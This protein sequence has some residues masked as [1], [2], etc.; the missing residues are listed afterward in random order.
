M[1]AGWDSLDR[2]FEIKYCQ[3]RQLVVV[4]VV[5]VFDAVC[6][7]PAQLAIYLNIYKN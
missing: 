1:S 7:Q 6:A 3:L 4:D 2:Y 5:D